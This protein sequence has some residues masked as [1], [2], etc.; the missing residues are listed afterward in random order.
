MVAGQ[1]GQP[2]LY[3]SSDNIALLLITN[4]ADIN[5]KAVN[6]ETPLDIAG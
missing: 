3:A 4:G 1:L 6:G 2:L 5:S